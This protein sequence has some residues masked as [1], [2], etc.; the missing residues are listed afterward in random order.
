VPKKIRNMFYS[1]TINT[2]I[3]PFYSDKS[4]EE[5]HFSEGEFFNNFRKNFLEKEIKIVDGYQRSK[6]L[7]IMN[8]LPTL[9]AIGNIKGQ[10]TPNK[11]RKE[12][13]YLLQAFRNPNELL[14]LLKI[15]EG[16]MMK[17][18]KPYL[19]DEY[20]ESMS[21]KEY[22]KFRAFNGMD[23]VYFSLYPLIYFLDDETEMFRLFISKRMLRGRSFLALKLSKYKE[24]L[25]NDKE[26]ITKMLYGVNNKKDKVV[27]EPERTEFEKMLHI[28]KSNNNDEWWK[29]FKN[30]LLI[31][32]TAQFR[33][34]VSREILQ[35]YTNI[36]AGLIVVK[37]DDYTMRM[38]IDS[39]RNGG[40][41]D[42]RKNVNDGSSTSFENDILA[43]L[44]LLTYHYFNNMSNYTVV[45]KINII[46]NT[47][48][49]DALEI[50]DGLE[51]FKSNYD[52]NKYDDETK[53]KAKEIIIEEFNS[54][55]ENKK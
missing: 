40:I 22:L 17:D 20:I 7:K 43:N 25:I 24:H 1:N 49:D 2:I 33:F 39:Y 14:D 32:L 51:Y 37:L 16:Y 38:I 54:Q 31:V 29:L 52:F 26:R 11:Y 3:F 42:I 44:F 4:L 13:N 48:I 19:F 21:Y 35:K 23:K 45:E 46:W 6:Q 50:A 12:Y 8:K 34:I 28:A 30:R 18:G 36:P 10:L 55:E 27:T 15:I 9:W 41:I 5:F 53:E 47:D